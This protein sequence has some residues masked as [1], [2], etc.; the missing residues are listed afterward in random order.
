MA[1]PQKVQY[2]CLLHSQYRSHAGLDYLRVQYP[3][4]KALARPIFTVCTLFSFLSKFPP[5]SYIIS[6]FPTLNV[7]TPHGQVRLQQ[8][9]H[10]QL[11]RSS[12]H[13]SSPQCLPRCRAQVRCPLT[14]P[15]A[16]PVTSRGSGSHFLP[17]LCASAHALH[18]HQCHC[19]DAPR[20]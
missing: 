12:L 2:R 11:S 18:P 3:H 8:L 7:A 13:S 19:R 9:V 20:S 4:T 16:V 10:D 5:V 17:P 1:Y 14:A 6:L 15:S